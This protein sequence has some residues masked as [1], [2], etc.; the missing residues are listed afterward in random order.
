MKKIATSN[1]SYE[2]Y[3]FP[4]LFKNNPVVSDVWSVA[5]VYKKRQA[6]PNPSDSRS[7]ALSVSPDVVN[8]WSVRDVFYGIAL[9]R[10]R[11]TENNDLPRLR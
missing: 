9:N 8:H 5:R 2:C 4:L 3:I 11:S 1:E 10:L 7:G 6:L